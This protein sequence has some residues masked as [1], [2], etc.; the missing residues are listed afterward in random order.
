MA[1]QPSLMSQLVHVAQHDNPTYPGHFG[2]VQELL[3][4]YIP[5]GRKVLE[6]PVI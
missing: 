3:I 5:L 1:T 2:L 6:L 4:L